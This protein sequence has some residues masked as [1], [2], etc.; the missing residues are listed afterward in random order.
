[1]VNLSAKDK[2]HLLKLK[3][4]MKTSAPIIESSVGKYDIVRFQVTHPFLSKRLIEL[5]ITTGRLNYRKCINV[6]PKKLVNHWIRG[7]FDGD[8]CAGKTKIAIH[9]VGTNELLEWVRNSFQEYTNIT[10][11]MSIRK[12]KHSRVSHMAIYGRIQVADASKWLYRN[13]T[14]WLERKRVILDKLS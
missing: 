14:I 6:I 2:K 9:F 11:K 13:A 10:S 12:F 1:M 7:F 3:D 5:G 4:F 8:G